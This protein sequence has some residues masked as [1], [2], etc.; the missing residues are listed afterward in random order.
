MI[1]NLLLWT[2]GCLLTAFAVSSCESDDVDYGPI[3]AAISIDVED[4]TP[5]SA[6]VTLSTEQKHVVS[7]KVVTPTPISEF[8]YAGHDAIDR[9]AFIEERGAAAEA[10]YQKTLGNLLPKVE[11]S[12]AVVGLD[13]AGQI[14]TA[15]TFARFTTAY[16]SSLVE[17]RFEANPDAT[18]TFTGK[19]TPNE[20]T[21]SYRYIFNSDHN[22]ATEAELRTLLEAGGSGVMTGEG[23]KNLEI[24]KAEKVGVTL[25]VLSYDDAARP[26]EF[27]STFVSTEDMASVIVDGKETQLARQAEGVDI[28]EGKVAVAAKSEFTIEINKVPYGFAPYS[29]NGGVGKV[30]N[31]MSAIPYYNGKDVDGSRIHEVKKA[32]GRMTEI[33]AG[34][35]NF[36]TNISAEA[37]LFVR[38]DLTYADGKPR[39][40]FELVTADDPKLVLEQNF[41]LFVWGGDYTLGKSNGSGTSP[42]ADDNKS[43]AKLD[44]TEEGAKGGAA[45]TDVFP[46]DWSTP[47]AVDEAENSIAGEVYLRNRDVEGWEIAHI[48]ELAGTIRMNRTSSAHKYS[49]WVMTPKLAKLSGATDITVEFDMCRFGDN[50]DDIHVTIV[51]AGAY[52]AAAVNPNGGAAQQVAASGQD[53]VI[54][55]ELCAGQSNAVINKPWTHVKLSVSGATAET[56]IKIDASKGKNSTNNRMMLDNI[57]ITK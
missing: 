53:F 51:G 33:T 15:P 29:G 13:A 31:L 38:V 10:P 7:Y 26:G 19:I 54:T 43:A 42:I 12:F 11:Y 30:E 32:I 39:Y 9:L 41:D 1:R 37:Q 14:V 8:E 48:A 49:G 50:A 40:Y 20:Y 5:S 36:W 24:T 46:D 21:V 52:T 55:P 28:F 56:R 4:V 23:V 34:G 22:D 45:Y 44:G 3:S 17:A 18:Y 25:A 6:K 47:G 57:K 35:N 16:A 27:T 2:A